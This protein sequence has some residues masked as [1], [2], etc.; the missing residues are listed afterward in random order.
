MVVERDDLVLGNPGRRWPSKVGDAPAFVDP[1][2]SCQPTGASL[3]A[4]AL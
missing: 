3:R 1:E 2:G 4:A